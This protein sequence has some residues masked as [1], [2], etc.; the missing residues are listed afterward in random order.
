MADDYQVLE[1]L[2]SKSACISLVVIEGSFS[3]H[4]TQAAP[5]ASSTAPSTSPLA[6]TLPSNTSIS[7]VATMTFA[8]SSK[9]SAF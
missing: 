2:G 7:K 1:E 5:S 3:L 8:R 9:R 6:N 4:I